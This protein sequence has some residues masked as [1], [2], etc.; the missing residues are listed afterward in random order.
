MYVYV[1]VY[2]IP[3]YE[4]DATI[5][6]RNLIGFNSEFSLSLTGCCIKVKEPSLPYP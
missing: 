6:K 3:P 4:Q 5:L 1:C 2:P